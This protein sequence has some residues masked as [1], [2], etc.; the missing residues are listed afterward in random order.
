MC[1]YMWT[2]ISIRVQIGAGICAVPPANAIATGEANSYNDV[3]RLRY[4]TSVTEM[5]GQG[6][7]YG[8]DS[9]LAKILYCVFTSLA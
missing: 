3:V 6:C 2:P 1:Y 7:T 8:N 9:C 5:I 4:I